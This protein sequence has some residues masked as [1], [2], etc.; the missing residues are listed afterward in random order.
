MVIDL[1][2]LSGYRRRLCVHSSSQ[3][4]VGVGKGG[5][6]WEDYSEVVVAVD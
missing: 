2:C 1:N 5:P 6:G 3:D 4:R